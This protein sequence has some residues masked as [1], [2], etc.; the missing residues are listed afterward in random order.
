MIDDDSQKKAAS[1]A[2]NCK[3]AERAQHVLQRR[4]REEA[5]INREM[6][7]NSIN[8]DINREISSTGEDTAA[9]H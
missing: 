7:I 6:R 3:K 9:T 5:Q 1:S 8:R 2:S 4:E